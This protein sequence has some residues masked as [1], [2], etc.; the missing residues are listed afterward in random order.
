LAKEAQV[1]AAGALVAI[2][3]RDGLL[4]G[5]STTTEE[6]DGTVQLADIREASFRPGLA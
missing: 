2:L 1:R 5:G 3:L 4:S 6:E